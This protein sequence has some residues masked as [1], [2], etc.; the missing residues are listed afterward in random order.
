[1]RKILFNEGWSFLKTGL[2]TE[3][4]RVR[5]STEWR[6]VDLPHDWLIYDSNNLY[7][8]SMGYYRKSFNPAQLPEGET[9]HIWL[10]FGAVYQ[11][12]T[13]YVNGIQVGEWKYGYNTFACEITGAL[14][15]GE[16]V[17]EVAV[18][19]ESPNSR[20]YS[21][22]GILRDVTLELA[23]ED[24]LVQDGSYVRTEK[25]AM[26]GAEGYKLR[27]STEVCLGAAAR[28]ASHE[29]S[30]G[31]KQNGDV[32]WE[33]R[34]RLSDGE[35]CLEQA[36]IHNN[37]DRCQTLVMFLPVDRLR[38]WSPDEPALYTLVTE[39][40]CLD[41]KTKNER[42]VDRY[43][44]RIG[45]KNVKLDPDRGLFLNG[46][47]LK[48][49]GVCL[50]HDLGALGGAFNVHALR[51]QLTIQKKMGV[52]A[53]R[54]SHN[55]PARELM[56]LADEMGF[57]VD[58]E[59]FDMWCLHKTEHDYATWFKE[60]APR[61]IANFVRRD[62]N[63]VSLLMWSVGNEIYD[64]QANPEEGLATIR[65]LK[66]ET[67]RHDP[68]GNGV[69]TF[70]SNF[71]EGEDTQTAAD[72]L[73]CVGY[74]YL[75][76]LYGEHHKKHPDWIL[77]GSETASTV[78]SRGVYHFPYEE[79]I[80][81][82]LDEQCSALG[83]CTT[84]WGAKNT[85]FCILTERDYD[86]SL[87]QF[88]WTGYD[89]IGEP[90]PYHTKNS[91]F[92]QVDTAG[93]AKDQ[94]YMYQAEWTD[95]KKAPM[96]HVFPY[97]DFNPG[98]MVDV[99]VC[100]NAPVVELF[101][102]GKSFG[103]CKLDHAHGT[104]LF[105]HWKVPYEP[106]ELCA[107]AYDEQ[108]AEL[109]RDVQRSFK[110]A[111]AITTTVESCSA[112][113]DGRDLYFIEIGMADEDGHPVCNANNR[114]NVHVEGPGRLLGLDN[115]DST[116]Y[117]S[118]KG[119]SRR[120]FNGKLLA[121]IG[122]TKKAG[123]IAVTITSEGMEK[124]RVYLTAE[125]PQREGAG[126]GISCLESNET[127]TVANPL[128]SE[129][130]H[131]IPIRKLEIRVKEPCGS[132][133][134]R[135]VLTPELDEVEL[136]AVIYPANATIRD[137][138]WVAINNA[139]AVTNLVELTANGTTACIK[140]MGD[141]HVNVRAY[142]R[143][144]AEK[145]S[146]ISQLGFDIEGIGSAYLNPY[147]PV[148]ASLYDFSFGELGKS[149]E[150]GIATDR[151]GMSYLGF[152]HV[153]FGDFGSDAITIPC[154]AF[155]SCKD[156]RIRVW[157]GIPEAEGSECLVDGIYNKETIWDTYIPETFALTHRIKGIHDIAIQT[158]EFINILGFTFTRC[159]KGTSEVLAIENDKLYGD[160]YTVTEEEIT[161][162]GNNVSI[163]FKGMDFGEGVT[164]IVIRGRSHIPKNTI[165]L[166]F[167]AADGSYTRQMVEVPY[168]ETETEQRFALE[169]VKGLVDLTMIFL[170]GS[171]FDLRSIR[172]TRDG[173]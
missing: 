135:P 22:A 81:V 162:I 51:R 85:E 124:Q 113:A 74:N 32:A 11:D 160:E 164:G 155:S 110:D 173:D 13:V 153:D 103:E 28:K 97:W 55:M 170:P 125:D 128:A 73:K 104:E 93:F 131:E 8:S 31:E 143:N 158:E 156:Y 47:H 27:I 29:L 126:D 21:G 14:H 62:R 148:S 108:H 122:T 12:S 70:A 65:M 152:S 138:T 92:G 23:G 130:E 25:T 99:R 17:I 98:Q 69:I 64:T 112:M 114:V 30:P 109:A 117:D 86:F 172:F 45:F 121:I 5:E 83:N 140:A 91:Y 168:S 111:V 56:D 137:I 72:E 24:Y 82:D 133:L 150:H 107:V 127:C 26:G 43:E 139:G 10:R 68:E 33:L 48:L 41:R 102:N 144:G 161:G 19:Y 20:W 6:P 142:T 89:Y 149:L 105:P 106:G 129:R 165:H 123:Y 39:L 115:G 163:D 36:A 18:R 171:R 67:L 1:M 159:N 59:M 50:H 58:D 145:V 16:N 54:T 2:G 132:S 34:Y 120:L 76:R 71:L 84:S 42:I 53:L 147:E 46:K 116:D 78:Q 77:Y 166:K 94:F 61:D 167:T 95:V 49:Q 169:R 79:Q 88:L 119:C 3:L 35:E 4:P 9:T 136:E 134:K 57:L 40:V 157:D 154:F 87:G 66:A 96:V 118:Y 37:V 38:E 146:V 7:E 151:N 60:W 90:T 141:G 15:E 63:H 101:V 80:L 52:N 44:E 75:E 100:S